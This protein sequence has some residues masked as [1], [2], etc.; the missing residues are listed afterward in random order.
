MWLWSGKVEATGCNADIWRQ[1][2]WNYCL[3]GT[4]GVK[5]CQ[6]VSNSQIWRLQFRH[7]VVGTVIRKDAIWRWYSCL[8]GCWNSSELF[9]DKIN[10]N[11]FTLHTVRFF[12]SICYFA[13]SLKLSEMIAENWESQNSKITCPCCISADV[14]L[15]RGSWVDT[16]AQNCIYFLVR[17]ETVYYQIFFFAKWEKETPNMIRMKFLHRIDVHDIIT[18]ANFCKNRLWVVF[19]SGSNFGLSNWFAL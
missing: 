12:I 10:G 6:R 11:N 3:Y 13:T 19:W 8:F 16:P 18:S 15:Q 9:L 4:G 7:S 5:R 2:T 1:T 14:Y 17:R